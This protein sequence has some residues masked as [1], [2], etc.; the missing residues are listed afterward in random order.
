MCLCA[1]SGNR[2]RIIDHQ[3]WGSKLDKWAHWINS[4]LEQGEIRIT[5]VSAIFTLLCHI[6]LKDSCR[7]WIIAIQSV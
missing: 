6:V 3:S 2:K 4:Q 1:R 5:V 7:F